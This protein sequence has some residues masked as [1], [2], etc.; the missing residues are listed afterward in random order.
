[1]REHSIRAVAIAVALCAAP[2]SATWAGE[3]ADWPQFRGVHR[4]GTSPETG[5]AATWPESGPEELWRVPIGEGY[6]AVSVVGDRLYT[7]YAGDLDGEPV[8]FAAAFD[9]AT[10]KE[11]WKT[12]IGAKYDTEFGNGPRATPTVAGDSVYVL[13]SYGD[14]AALA[15]ADGAVRWSLNVPESFGGKQPGWGYSTSPVVEGD[16]LVLET[17]GPEG[18]SYAGVATDSGDVVWTSGDGPAGYNSALPIP[19]GE[20][21]R[22]VYVA[23]GKLRSI[24]ADGKEIWS[25]D[26]PRGETHAMPVFVPPDRVYASGAEGIGAKLVRFSESADG[27]SVETVWE[28]RFMR[29]HF[30][31][32]VYVDGLIFGF[33][34]ATLKAIRAEDGTLAWAKRGLGKGALILADGNLIVLS[35]RGELLL[36]EANGEEYRERGRVQALD[37]KCWTAPSLSHG[38]LYLRNHEEMVAYDLAK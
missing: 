26:W 27:G 36:V 21:T 12:K 3:G 37:G 35:D 6:S 17:G 22:L 38:K 2:G 24:D 31:S 23:G 32:S 5:L 15:T 4:D 8:E 14:L 33:D 25:M 9:A 20:A 28:S 19:V 16:L 1:M 34:N 7:M 18:K 11:L 30:S 13:G 29:N 10:G